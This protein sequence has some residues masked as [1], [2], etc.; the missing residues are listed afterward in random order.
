MNIS[1][2]YIC[3]YYIK[4]RHLQPADTLKSHDFTY[5][6]ILLKHNSDDYSP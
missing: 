3:N 6:G 5:P 1:R 4:C 2:A